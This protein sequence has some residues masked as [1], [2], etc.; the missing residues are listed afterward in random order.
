MAVLYPGGMSVDLRLS[1][2]S[3]GSGALCQLGW[4]L[5]AVHRNAGKPLFLVLSGSPSSGVSV[6]L[7]FLLF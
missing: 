6:L 3:E 7:Y 2:L 1:G 5:R 4:V